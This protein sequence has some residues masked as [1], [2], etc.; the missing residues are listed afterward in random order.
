MCAEKTGDDCLCNGRVIYGKRDEGE[1]VGH[2]HKTGDIGID[3]IKAT[4]G[5]WTV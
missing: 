3:G 5:Y 2:T 4:H 1:K